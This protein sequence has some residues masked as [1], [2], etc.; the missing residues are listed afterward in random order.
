M[1]IMID[2]NTLQEKWI[3]RW[4][5][6]KLFESN[7]NNDKKYFVTVA[8][9][10]P[11]SPQHIGHGRTYTLADVHARYM[12]MRGYNVL[13]PMAFH[14]TGTPILAM[15]KRVID[16]DQELIN[17]F[18]D[19]YKV[20]REEIAKFDDPLNIAKYF[21]NEIKQGMIEMGYSIDWRR[22]FTTIDRLYSKF[23]EW[24]F[25]RLRE[26][27]YI[28]Q[29]SHPVG[30]C[31]RDNNPVSQ[32]DTLG[33]VEPDFNEYT[34]IKFEYDGIKIPT[35]TLR[36]E[37]IFG[38]TNLWINPD[39][40]YVKAKV[41]SEIWI[42][43]KKS[44]EKL[45]YL[46]RSVEIVE[47][48]KGEKLLKAKVKIPINNRMVEVLPASFVDADNGTGIVM[49]VPA[50]AP[51][52]YQALID[53]GQ[54][55]EPIV[56]IESEKYKGKVPAYE[57]IKEFGIKGQNDPKLEDAT[58]ELYSQEFYNG[59]MIDSKYNGKSV[60]ES[61]DLV[62]NDLIKEGKADTMLE[63]IN[64][65]RCRCGA[66]CVVKILDDQWFIDY[67]QRRW[68]DLAHECLDNMSLIPEDIRK[69]FEYT[70]EWLRE[71]ACARRSGLGTKLPWD[72]DWII[73]SLSDS[74]IYM[75]YY[76]IAK[77]AEKI[78]DNVDDDLFNYIFDGKG[79]V[80]TLAERYG[81]DKDLLANI[82][83]EFEYYYP[84]DSRHSGRD[85]IPNHLTFFIFNHVAI[86]DRERWPKEI[87]VNGSVLMEGK[88]MSKSMGNIIPLRQ[89][90]KEH[91]ADAIRSAI[92]ITAELLQDAD[93]TFDTLEGIKNRLEKI[94]NTS[95]EVEEHDS[96]DR[97]DRW[98]DSVL[99][100]KIA[101]ITDAMNKLR[102]REAL[103][104]IIY[105]MDDILQWYQKRKKAKGSKLSLKRFF[106][107]RVRLLAPF[108][109]FITEEIWQ[110]FGNK[111]SIMKAEWPI[112]DEEKIDYEADEGEILIMNL[113]EDIA[114]ILKVT[115]IKPNTIYIYTASRDKHKLYAD[116]LQLIIDGKRNFRDIMKALINS[117]REQAKK[118]PDM[119]K[120][121][122]DDILAV[123]EQARKRRKSIMLDEKAAIDDAIELLEREFN[124]K[125]IVYREDEEII[126]PRSRARLARPYKP[127][128]YIE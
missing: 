122:T 99:Q 39:A 14:Y 74:V 34:L 46:N 58:T 82:K 119:V 41:D 24:Q 68:K 111:E 105:G 49:S 51:Y 108:A 124:A 40:I 26:K 121:M 73:E 87:V 81:V 29:G 31:P 19:I 114:S 44:S 64:P 33:D 80:N 76:T 116:I 6:D 7:P 66:E 103:H 100:Y 62:K 117:N 70:I 118:M 30:W 67:S 79:D 9:P 110:M 4:K 123:S 69:E 126:D 65:V 95:K 16:N 22:E 94:Y 113:L 96:N 72:K 52:D 43:S 35:A 60:R 54:K 5:E 125:I 3:K 59:I 48:F 32:H 88:K 109:P 45:R 78:G 92:M 115:K 112:A 8:Y 18:I 27:G 42:I 10:Y 28:V 1:S 21:H 89:A 20:P 53:L 77:Y 128:L 83:A 17:T 50:H 2:Y 13:F 55:F 85:L 25:K 38:V 57:V 104:E 11:N 63:L 36:P 86:F 56:I 106:D 75:A 23:I 37:T 12:R 91:G 47:E 98:L 15:S 102:V 61:R 107:V 120:K 127:A 93:F 90:I 84:V 97:I 71:R 101:S